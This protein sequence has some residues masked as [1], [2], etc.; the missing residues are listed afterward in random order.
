MLVS[1]V[2]ELHLRY[3]WGLLLPGNHLSDLL[4]AADGRAGTHYC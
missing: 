2:E 4:L 1:H 3:F